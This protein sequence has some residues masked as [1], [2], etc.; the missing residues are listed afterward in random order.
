MS[1]QNTPE[2]RHRRLFI[3]SFIIIVL[4]ALAL[5]YVA[6]QFTLT[7]HENTRAAEAQTS[8]IAA[9]EQE[10]ASQEA[11][12]AE[13]SRAIEEQQSQIG[14]QQSELDSRQS[15]I[16]S[17]Q[18]EIDAQKSKIDSL[19]KQLM[20]K[21]AASGTKTGS[22]A[23]TTTKKPVPTGKLIA[24]TFDDG[25]GPYTAQLLDAMKERGVHATFFLIGKNVDKYPAVVKRMEAE[26]HTVGN[27]TQNH[28]NLTKLS[29]TQVR[30]E[31]DTCSAK[32]EKVIGHKPTVLRCPGGNCNSTV[33]AYA[34]SLGMPVFYWSV[35]TRDWESRNVNSILT[36]AFQ[37]NKYGIQENAI[38]LM[39]DIY[40]TSLTAAIEM[41][42]K[43]QAQGYTMVTVPD[44]LE[45]RYGTVTPGKV[46]HN[47]F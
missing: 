36:T 7:K 9:L 32:I 2:R 1:S 34:K 4:L 16:D 37:K 12:L 15:R 23:A 30:T 41:M 31:I 3:I 35:D 46:Y 24:L 21:K 10:I 28:K 5:A 20:S 43:L 22:T 19:N 29:A 27:H 26:G 13:N 18:S 11:Q 44:L 47:A 33:T 38:V 39:H 6:I 40:K 45:A 25:P 14:S 17:Q 42:D 8:R